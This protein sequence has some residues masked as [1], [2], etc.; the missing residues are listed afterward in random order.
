MRSIFERFEHNEIL[1]SDGALGTML[2]EKGLEP[3]Q[4][5]EIL[6][7]NQPELLVEIARSY[8]D[9]GADILH[10]NTFGASPLKLSDFGIEDKADEINKAGVELVK[11][12][13]N[14]Q[15][16]VSASSG[17][18]G[19]IL[20]P[21][22]S[23]EPETV[24]QSY[25]QQMQS[26]I[27]AGADIITIETMI[28]IREAVIAI[29]AVREIS[30]KIPI[31]ATMSFDKTP[32]GFYTIMGTN[33]K[34][35]AENLKKAGADIIG[36]NCGNGLEMMIEIAYAFGRVTSL[37]VIIQSNAGLPEIK[38]GEIKYSESASFF[39]KFTP[40]LIKAGVSILGG[41]CGTTPDYIS[42]MKTVC[43]SL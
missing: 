30:S 23:A 40:E 21:Y 17:P 7:L 13:A 38:N 41:C 33:I 36:S 28:D 42:E 39:G 5:P 35:A 16:Y 4:C 8:L 37:P 26:L 12:V 32:D 34:D 20:Q 29:K 11:S 10:T 22:G 1:V 2:F 25:L 43:M 19:K 31:I 27:E 14:D 24:F 15:A 3:G 9:A 6:N 18:T